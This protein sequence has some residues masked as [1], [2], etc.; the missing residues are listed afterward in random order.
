MIHVLTT[1]EK[2]LLWEQH[3]VGAKGP[4]PTIGYQHSPFE[5]VEEVSQFEWRTDHGDGSHSGAGAGW[6][7]NEREFYTDDSVRQD[8]SEHG[9]LVITARR[10]SQEN[11]PEDW[12]NHPE[13]EYV[14]GKITTAGLLSFQYGYIEAR[15][16]V[17][18]DAG[19][20]SAFWL[21]GENLLSGTPWPE[22]GEIDI[23]ESVGQEP[24]CLLGTVHGP[25]YCADD[26][27]TKKIH[28][29]Q[30]LSDDFHTYGVL[31]LPDRIEWYFD[32]EKFHT[33]G[34]NEVAPH[35]WV[36]N[37]P[38]YMI[39]N[40]AMGGNLGG[41][42]DPQVQSCELA[43]DYIRHYAVKESGASNFVGELIRH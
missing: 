41:P 23:L 38:F 35:K 17:P 6:G 37:Q 19:S 2:K 21:L 29:V 15:I 22:C 36:F 33:L 13:W 28:H 10:I 14:S 11:G 43:V 25:G 20:W 39:V 18:T 32:G 34:V 31:W 42:L 27:P 7:N 12:Q 5:N 30:P 1:L 4:V 16:K 8:G 3:F 24:H 40:L 26:G 9:S